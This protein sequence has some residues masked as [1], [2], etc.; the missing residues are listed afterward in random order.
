VNLTID[1][2]DGCEWR[3]SRVVVIA[4]PASAV[5]SN[6]E[7]RTINRCRGEAQLQAEVT[8][9]VGGLDIWSI[10]LDHTQI[11]LRVSKQ[12]TT[13]PTRVGFQ[14]SAGGDPNV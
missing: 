13:D 4:V 11:R 6:V 14:S 9:T 8:D 10:R 7:V 12:R 3:S 1:Q 2:P 5:G